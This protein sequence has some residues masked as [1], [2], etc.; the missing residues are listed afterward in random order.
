MALCQC[1][2]VLSALFDLAVIAESLLERTRDELAQTTDN[3]HVKPPAG[4][5]ALVNIVEKQI[6]MLFA[7]LGRQ[8]RHGERE[9]LVADVRE[10]LSGLGYGDGEVDGVDEDATYS[11]GLSMSF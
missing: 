5:E 9:S 11:L 8:V 10:A 3:D 6:V 2:G 4:L 7:G 1:D